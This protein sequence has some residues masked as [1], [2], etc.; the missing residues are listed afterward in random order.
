[1][2]NAVISALASAA[3]IQHDPSGTTTNTGAETY[4]VF[5]ILL[6]ILLAWEGEDVLA[7]VLSERSKKDV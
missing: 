4:W 5:A 3:S 7:R 6:L 1:M 2:P